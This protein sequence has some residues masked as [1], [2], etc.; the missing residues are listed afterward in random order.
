MRETRDVRVR[1]RLSE[2]LVRMLL[3]RLL[4]GARGNIYT[5]KARQICE[6]ISGVDQP[7]VACK[8]AVRRFVLALLYE[9]IVREL[10]NKYRIVV[11]VKKARELLDCVEYEN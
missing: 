4:S 2:Q 10:S 8:V 9:A 1:V 11:D 7:S 3:C 5:I 6:E